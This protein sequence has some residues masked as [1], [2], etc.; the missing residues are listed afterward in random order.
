MTEEQKLISRRN[1][2]KAYKLLNVQKGWVLHHKDT[3]LRHNDIERYILWLPEDL[4][5]M[6]NAD[7]VKLHWQ[8]D[9]SRR[10]KQREA[11]IKNRNWVGENNPHYGSHES[12]SKG[13]TWK[14]KDSSKMGKV[15]PYKHWKLVDGKR[16]WYN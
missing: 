12:P 2:Y 10:A 11:A 7:H 13:K 8:L 9:D 16:V 3:N 6:K 4:E 15:H 1:H 5:V 14:V